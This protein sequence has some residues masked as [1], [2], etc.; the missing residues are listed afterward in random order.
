MPRKRY[1]KELK[2]IMS[3]VAKMGHLSKDALWLAVEAL[4]HNQVN[5]VD[6]VMDKNNEIDNLEFRTESRIMVLIATQQPRGY[7]LRVIGTAL[8]ILSDFDRLGDLA[9]NIA[10]IVIHDLPQE[11]PRPPADEILEMTNLADTMISKTLESFENED[12]VPLE[13]IASLE[14]KMD[15]LFRTVRDKMIT[16][17]LANPKLIRGAMAYSFVSRY[18]ERFGDHICNIASRVHYMITGERKKIE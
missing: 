8:K 16:S 11:T 18:L 12:N 14:D 15:H 13:E 7:D 9:G 1:H 10:K 3:Q 2:D 6:R 17:V 5:R 4:I